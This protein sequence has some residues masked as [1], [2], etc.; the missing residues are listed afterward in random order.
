MDI[1]L[2]ETELRRDEGVKYLPYQDNSPQ[3][4]STV[5]IG[6]NLTAFPM[7][8]EIYPMTDGRVSQVLT[9]DLTRT[10]AGLDACLPWWRALDEVRQ[11]VVANMAFNMGVDGLLTFVNTLKAIQSGNYRGAAVG[12]RASQWAVEVGARAV[13]LADAMQTG[14]MPA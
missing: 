14:I 6:H 8:G 13:R 7:P 10:F 12:M 5:G 4:N 3:K 2:L 9:I 11:R 1:N